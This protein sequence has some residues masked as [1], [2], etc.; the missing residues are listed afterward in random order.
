MAA[1]PRSRW[2]RAAAVA[3][4]LSWLPCVLVGLC[5]AGP[6]EA[7][8]HGCCARPGATTMSA[9]P[10]PCWLQSPVPL[11]VAPPPTGP[12]APATIADVHSHVATETTPFRAPRT[13]AFSALA[14]VLRI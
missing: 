8:A 12:G 6:S 3:I 7:S 4:L 9:A 2:V 1:H 14:V 11:P 5:M 13:P 10:E